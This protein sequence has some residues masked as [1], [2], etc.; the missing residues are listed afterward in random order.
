[1][2]VKTIDITLDILVMF[3]IW[4]YAIAFVY[5]LVRAALTLG[6]LMPS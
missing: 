2:I 3:T 6:N 4:C 5:L 1:M